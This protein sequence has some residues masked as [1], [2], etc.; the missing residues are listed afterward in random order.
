MFFLKKQKIGKNFER[1]RLWKI[2]LFQEGDMESNYVHGNSLLPEEAS[3]K[4]F[5]EKLL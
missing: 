2:A 3:Q 5:E 4:C 1:K